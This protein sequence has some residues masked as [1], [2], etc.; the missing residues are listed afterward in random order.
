MSDL[1]NRWSMSAPRRL[2]NLEHSRDGPLAQYA[3]LKAET[4]LA[5]KDGARSTAGSSGTGRP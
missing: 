3:G 4:T 1:T 5:S 2:H